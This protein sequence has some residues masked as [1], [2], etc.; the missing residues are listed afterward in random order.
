[1]VYW[2]SLPNSEMGLLSNIGTFLQFITKNEKILNLMKWQGRQNVNAKVKWTF[3]C[4][5][6]NKRIIDLG[7]VVIDTVI[8][9]WN[10]L[11]LVN[12]LLQKEW[13]KTMFH[14]KMLDAKRWNNCPN[15]PFANYI[16]FIYITFNAIE[17]FIISC[18]KWHLKISKLKDTIYKLLWIWKHLLS[19]WDFQ[20]DNISPTAQ[21]YLSSQRDLLVS[22]GKEAC[23]YCV[24]PI[25]HGNSILLAPIPG[26]S[27][28]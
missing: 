5:I 25:P 11:H 7:R 15:D 13:E 17:F 23:Q 19:P 12:D 14:F 26:P 8:Y 18:T 16:S 28:L 10:H 2:V 3:K 4:R 9:L 21:V 27:C 6:I 1:M 20:L 22:Y 24:S